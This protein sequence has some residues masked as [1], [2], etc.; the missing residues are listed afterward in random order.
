MRSRPSH[1]RGVVAAFVVS[2]VAAGG[3]LAVSGSAGA[4]DGSFD[5]GVNS[6]E[7][8]K[9][10]SCDPQT[11]TI[12]FQ[13]FAAAP[14]V[15]PWKAGAD[16]GGATAQ[17]VTRTKIK[18]VVLWSTPSTQQ[19]GMKGA[20]LNQ[21]TGQN[22]PNAEMLGTIDYNQVFAHSYETWGRSL[23]LHFVRATGADETAQRADA[24]TVA[25]MKPFAVFD[26][27]GLAQTAG[28]GLVFRSQIAQRGVPFVY[29]PALPAKVQT[30]RW[31]VNA[32]EFVGKSLAGRKAKWAGDDAMKSQPRKFGVIYSGFFDID[33]FKAQLKKYGVTLTA[34][35]SFSLPTDASQYASATQEQAPILITKLKAAG[36]NNVLLLTEYNGV[37]NATRAATTQDF[38]P[39][40]T[41]LMFPNDLDILGRTYDQKQ[42][43]HAFGL[44]WFEPHVT[45]LVDPS[46]AIF[47]WFWGTD[48]GTAW[49]GA[50]PPLLSLY[51]GAQL[52]GPKLTGES[53]KAAW[54]KYPG[55]GGYFSKSCCTMEVSP[56]PLVWGVSLGWWSADT[57][58]TGQLELGG[59]AAGAWMY[60]NNARRYIYGH[61]PKGEPKFFDASLAV[62]AF[63]AVPASE[64]KQPTYPCDGCPSTGADSPTPATT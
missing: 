27:T 7:A 5:P 18:V 37:G 43:A 21:A 9:N 34:E 19:L 60:M 61:F 39:E 2:A 55:T 46:R 20:Y 17:G 54:N 57:V 11:K 35:T 50:I 56:D 30:R 53:V 25:A 6:T 36:V 59:T 10:A 23:D 63:D 3:L 45:G 31:A 42:W 24:V 15:K 14:C 62:P 48:Q 33:Y 32:A 41:Q 29:P 38:Y 4:A 22:D 44:V 58:A 49:P 52:A 26:A 16:N 28:G 8:L 51:T 64:P 1:T 13:H 40:W 12:K 47:Q